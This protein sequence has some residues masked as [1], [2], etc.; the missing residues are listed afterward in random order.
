MH[1]SEAVQ[2][3]WPLPASLDLVRA[4]VDSVASAVLAEVTRFVAGERLSST[5][6]PFAAID[7]VFAS[8]GVFTDVP[9]VYFVLPTH[10]DWTVLW[11]N[12][13][14]CDGYD[15]LCWCLTTNH[16]LTTM[17]WLSSDEDAVFQA[18]SSFTFRKQANSGLN[19]RCVY[20]G[21]N[22]KRWEFHALG[23][24]L[25][26][27]DTAAYSAR[28]IRDRL[29]EQGMLRLLGK[30]GARPWE[31]D[32]YRAGEACRIERL[33]YPDRIMQMNFPEFACKRNGIMG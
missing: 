25:T 27:E 9:T 28:R 20:C 12:S 13:F 30:L 14:L 15:S 24:P 17:H 4:P 8:V 6:V 10:S 3:W 23:D 22:D 11:N 33:S 1:I 26:E 7:Q 16:G 18:G 5:W 31:D 19:E 2:R 29:N 32:F 21:K